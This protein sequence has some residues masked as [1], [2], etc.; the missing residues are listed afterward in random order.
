MTNFTIFRVFRWK[1]C[2]NWHYSLGNRWSA[3]WASWKKEG[4]CFSSC[5][6]TQVYL[7]Y[8]LDFK[9]YYIEKK[10]S[11]IL[12]LYS[13]VKFQQLKTCVNHASTGVKG[14]CVSLRK[15]KPGFWNGQIQFY[16]IINCQFVCFSTNWEYADNNWSKKKIIDKKMCIFCH[17]KIGF[18]SIWIRWIA[19][20]KELGTNHS[21]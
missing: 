8:Y 4:S 12:W 10:G 3:K 9:Y 11:T 1:G 6:S 18:W 14:K 7:L 20:K 16:L 2:F 19:K 15:K 17:S 21:P 13:E 5:T